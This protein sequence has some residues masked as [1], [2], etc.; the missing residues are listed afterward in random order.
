MD[1]ADAERVIVATATPVRVA[2]SPIFNGGWV[3][4]TAGAV[5]IWLIL[6]SLV[7]RELV[8]N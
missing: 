5:A 3:G 2:N 4:G 1:F 8:L 6:T 7:V